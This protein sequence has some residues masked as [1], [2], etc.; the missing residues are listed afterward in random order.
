MN[1]QEQKNLQL[2][3]IH[4]LA[5]GRRKFFSSKEIIA[6]LRKMPRLM[7]KD[8]ETINRIIRNAGY[9]RHDLENEKMLKRQNKQGKNTWA[10]TLRGKARVPGIYPDP[11]PLPPQPR[12]TK[13]EAIA[14]LTEAGFDSRALWVLEQKKVNRG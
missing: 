4:R 13:E 6:E 5:Q 10:L 11:L 1:T 8:A 12:P 3:A 14:A 7:G 9:R 2:I